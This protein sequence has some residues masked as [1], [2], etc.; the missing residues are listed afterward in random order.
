MEVTIII[1][2]DV[3]LIAKKEDIQIDIKEAIQDMLV[4]DGYENSE[5][6]EVSIP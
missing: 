1:V 4:M 2:L 5:L 6:I 3:P